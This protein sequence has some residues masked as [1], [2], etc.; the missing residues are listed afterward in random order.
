MLSLSVCVSCTDC[1]IM[2]IRC[3]RLQP[4]GNEVKYY[5][6]NYDIIYVIILKFIESACIFGKF[7]LIWNQHYERLFEHKFYLM[8]T[9][10]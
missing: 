10:I 3:A 5:K 2:Y 9:Y 8:K 4:K 7:I 1:L 6:V